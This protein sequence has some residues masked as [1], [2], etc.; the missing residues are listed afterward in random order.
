MPDIIAISKI[1]GAI[2]AI[3]AAVIGLLVWLRPV[4]IIA[5]THLVLDG[6][7][8]DEIAAT[9][10]N[11]SGKPI[12]VVSCVSK[13]T[14]PWRYTFMRHI[15]QPFLAPRLYPVIRYG[16]PTH[17]LLSD[18]PIK[19][20]PQQPIELRHLLGSHALSKF[21]T[22]QFLIEIQ[23]S[24]GRKFRSSRQNVPARWRLQRAI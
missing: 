14:Y 12:Y 20:E 15:R 21:H 3:L 7:G 9:I 2:A 6:S 10:T 19:V 4:R 24:N 1:V 23:L 18:G 17:E 11:R 22:G 16:G 5:G 13:G 8:P